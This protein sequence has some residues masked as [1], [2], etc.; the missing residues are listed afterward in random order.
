MAM[1]KG[2]M[3]SRAYAE[4]VGGDGQRRLHRYFVTRGTIT[5]IVVQGA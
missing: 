3:T 4:L 1:S 5:R 2:S